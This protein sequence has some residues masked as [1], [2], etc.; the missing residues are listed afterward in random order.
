MPII[1]I[2]ITPQTKEMKE[3]M[4]KKVTDEL[5]ELIQ[6]PKEFFR[7]IINEVEPENFGLAGETLLK[8]MGEGDK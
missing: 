6:I 3:K 2:D 4:I 7:I 5:S 1:K 8:Y